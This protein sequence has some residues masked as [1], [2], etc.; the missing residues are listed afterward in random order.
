MKQNSL[1][2]IAFSFA[3]T[4]LSPASLLAQKEEK[5]K[6]VKEK[7]DVQQVII[8]RKNELKCL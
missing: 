3:F 2:L 6:E 5:A 4:V 7:K 1:K 8:T